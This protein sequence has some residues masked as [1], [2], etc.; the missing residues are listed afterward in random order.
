MLDPPG[1]TQSTAQTIS[2]VFDA[3]SQEEGQG[4]DLKQRLGEKCPLEGRVS[5]LAQCHTLKS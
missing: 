2:S 4:T 5:L 1:E 3:G